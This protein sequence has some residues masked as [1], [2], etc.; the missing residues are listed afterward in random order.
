MVKIGTIN[1]EKGGTGKTS[2]T[3]NLGEYAAQAKNKRVL[4]IDQDKS[5]NLSNR[6]SKYDVGLIRDENKIDNL[7]KGKEIQPIH[8]HDNL[9]LLVAGPE[10]HEMDSFIQDKHNNR[11]I[12]FAWITKNYDELNEKYDYILIDTHNDTTLVTQNAWAVAD[13]VIGVS[14]PS[15]DGYGALMKLGRDIEYLKKDLVEVI[16]GTSYVV[17]KYFIIGNKVKH[18]TNSSREFRE[19]IEIE[20]NYLG[21]IQDKELINTGNLEMTPIVE[22]ANDPKT[23][24]NHKEFFTSTF[25]VYDKILNVLD[26]GEE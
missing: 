18:N 3:F 17:A 2:Q 9:D 12:L 13:V 15:M 10:L 5:S 8:I 22:Y 7:Y 19:I 14:D 4:L 6:Y 11:L 21:Y 23:F 26:A 25:A 20:E 24:Q 1:I 16:S